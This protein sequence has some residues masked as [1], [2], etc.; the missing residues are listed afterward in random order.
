V[1]LW[2]IVVD[3][4]VQGVPTSLSGLVFR[5][6][7]PCLAGEFAVLMAASIVLLILERLRHARDAQKFA[8]DPPSA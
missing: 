4:A 1:F 2:A 5:V 6:G 3:V 8:G 7:V